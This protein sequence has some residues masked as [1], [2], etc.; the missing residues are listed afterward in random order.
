MTFYPLLS[1]FVLSLFL[2]AAL[3][4]A[5][6]TVDGTPEAFD[7]LGYATTTG[8]FDGD[9]FDDL[10]TGAPGE[11]NYEGAVHVV[12]GD[13]NGLTSAGDDV[14]S[15][16]YPGIIGVSESGDRFGAAVAAGDFNGDGFDDL[17]AGVPNESVGA[18]ADAGAV[19]VLYG[20]A[21]GL[22]IS[23]NQIWTQNDFPPYSSE[24]G[25]LFGQALAVG[26]FN[27]D[28]F[29]DL[30]VGSPGE[31]VFAPV[32]GQ[33][34]VI[35]GSA[36]GL[37]D[38]DDEV[39]TLA[40]TTP[41]APTGGDAFGFALVAG[42]FILDIGLQRDELAIGVPGLNVDGED[43]AGGVVVLRGAVGGL[44]AIDEVWT[45]DSRGIF[46]DPEANE[47]FGYALAAG[48]FD[49]EPGDDLA[50]GIPYQGINGA[51]E[52]GTVQLFYGGILGLDPAGFFTQGILGDPADDGDHFGRSLTAGDFDGDGVDDLAVGAEEHLGTIADAG[53]VSVIFGV[54]G[55][56]L[57][58][59]GARFIHQNKPGPVKDTAEQLD[60]FGWSLAAGDF[61]GNGKADLAVG[62]PFETLD[63]ALF[64]GAVNVVSFSLNQ[65]VRQ[66]GALRPTP[67]VE[68]GLLAAGQ[69]NAWVSKPETT[70]T[71][72]VASGVLPETASLAAAFPNPFSTRTTLAFA[73]PE[74]RDVRLTVFDALGR[75]VAVVLAE[76][77]EAGH[78]TV[79][80]DGAD[81]PSGV[82]VVRLTAGD[83]VQTQRL[84]LVR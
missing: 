69:D 12:Y 65:F 47:Q 60:R 73:L 48:N 56:G 15:Q 39:W 25:D 33:V 43:A 74:A 2:L 78:H 14:W 23:G 41:L 24:A 13:T 17:A 44:V 35:Y 11:N 71:P 3:P 66:G 30:A 40:N 76:R 79:S 58:H 10:A 68:V 45:Q 59:V 37:T 42:N 21:G 62:V 4:A 19:N 57:S 28:G 54:P 29:D 36:S 72:A 83:T 32:A 16:G 50:V 5:A 63:G 53:A 1:R 82:Y 51:T 38:V 64:A 9:G 80:F 84:A 67:E 8:D 55:S 7:L 26:D 81:L 46:S 20:A 52:G 6:Q 70:S 31:D 49:S 18:L 22:T 75:E 77:K 61:D 34:H 27:G